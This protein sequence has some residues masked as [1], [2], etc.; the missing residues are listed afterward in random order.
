LTGL[1]LE[2][3]AA[4][5]AEPGADGASVVI[6]IHDVSHLK[7]L[8]RMKSEFVSNVSHELRT[9]ITTIKLYVALIRKSPEKLKEYLDLLTREANRQARLIEDILQ[10]SRIDAGRIELKPRPASLND[11][12]EMAVVNYGSLARGHGLSLEHRPADPSPVVLV[13]SERMTQVLANL[14]MNA[15]RYTPEGGAVQVSTGREEAEGRLWAT[16]T[17][18][19]TGIGIPA[20]ELP[21]IFERF[22]RGERPRT[23][24][25]SGTGLGL[26]ITK[27]IVGLHGGHI[28]A[29]SQVD[30]GTTFTVWLPLVE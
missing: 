23:M 1:D 12:I 24:Q 26:A 21:H 9:P 7:A 2:L 19:D 22:F 5:I 29:E 11:L 4:P 8:D 13:D 14:L 3:R 28:T 10:T 18:T 27:E 25:V 15:I 20:E 16:V 6:A 30:V 17:V